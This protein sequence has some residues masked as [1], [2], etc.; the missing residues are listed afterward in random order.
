VKPPSALLFTFHAARAGRR[1]RG[2]DARILRHLFHE[3][4]LK[5]RMQSRIVAVLLLISA[6]SLSDIRCSPCC[7]LRS[8]IPRWP[9]QRGTE[10]RLSAMRS[11]SRR[12]TSRNHQPQ[13]RGCHHP[14]CPPPPQ[15]CL[16][17]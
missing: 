11:M 5:T 4:W 6:T 9:R 14:P 12:C 3:T 7:G 1:D 17:I 8:G 2:V 16:E 10:S 15:Q 13:P